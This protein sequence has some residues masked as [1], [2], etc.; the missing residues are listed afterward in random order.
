MYFGLALSGGGIRGAVHI[1]ILQGLLENNLYPDVIAGSSAGSLV[2]LLFCSGI[3][4][5]NMVSLVSQYED[6]INSKVTSTLGIKIPAGL[7]KADYI[8]FALRTLTRGKSFNQLS[9]KLAVMTTDINTGQ[10]IIYTSSDLAAPPTNDFIFYHDAK[11][12]EAVRASIAIPGIFAP[13]RIGK[14]TLVDGSLVS[15]VPVDVLK[16]LGAKYIVGIN[17]GFGVSDKVDT[18]PQIIMQTIS[19]M[20]QR[21]TKR[22]LSTYAHLIIEPDTGQVNFWE[23]QK[24]GQLIELG[25]QAVYANLTALKELLV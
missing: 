4:P 5:G 20:G 13:K 16:I 23:V 21:L 11:P 8:E 19:I 22:I 17:L 14:H 25:K 2:G 1:G 24:I 15:H 7:I 9:P 10:G 6:S 18:A 3:A 12:W